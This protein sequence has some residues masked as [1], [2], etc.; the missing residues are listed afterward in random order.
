MPFFFNSCIL[1]AFTTNYAGG[2]YNLPIIREMMNAT[3]G[4]NIGPGQ[5]LDIGERNFNLLRIH[6]AEEG[7]TRSKDK[8]PKRFNEVLPRGAS[9]G[10]PISEDKIEEAIDEYYELRGWE[11]EGP[12][13]EKLRSLGMGEVV[14]YIE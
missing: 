1:C 3:T 14:K 10:S 12:S 2:S 4:I 13:A 8:L 6:S 11:E 9:T 5:M 7:Y